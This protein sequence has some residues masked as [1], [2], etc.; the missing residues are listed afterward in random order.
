M[1]IPVSLLLIGVGAILTWAVEDRSSAVNLD[2]VGIILM[3]VGAVGLL[4]TLVWWERL[5][6]GYRRTAH[7]VDEPAVGYGP[8]YDRRRRTVVEEDVLPPPGY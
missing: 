4:L 5:G 7:Y 2:A 6:F 8:R 3:V 1:G